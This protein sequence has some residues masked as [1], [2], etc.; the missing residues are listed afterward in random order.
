MKFRAVLTAA[1]L[2]SRLLFPALHAAGPDDLYLDAYR[3][4]QEGDQYS[5]AGQTDIA[6]QRYSDAETNLK[7]IQVSYPEYNKNAVEFRLEYIREHTK[8]LPA[9]KAENAQPAAPKA[10]RAA[11]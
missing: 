9:P 10:A 4:I 6:R 1:A 11:S 3:L 5:S 8:G 2:G 7:K